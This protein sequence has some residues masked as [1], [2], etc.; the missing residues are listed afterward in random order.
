MNDEKFLSQR[1]SE[2]SIS[3][4]A[5]AIKMK[6]KQHEQPS[7]GLEIG[8]RVERIN[9]SNDGFLRGMVGTVSDICNSGYFRV[10]L[11]DGH[12]VGNNS[13]SNLKIVKEDEFK[14]GDILE[15]IEDVNLDESPIVKVTEVIGNMITHI[16]KGESCEVIVHKS[17]FKRTDKK[18]EEEWK[19]ITK[20]CELKLLSDN[21]C[22]CKYYY[23]ELI[24]EGSE[25]ARVNSR[26]EGSKP[27]VWEDSKFKVE[28][29]NNHFR[30]LKKGG[31]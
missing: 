6:E 30:I 28:M 7:Y 5:E 8:V 13:R 22:D 21:D 17:S 31:E 2:M 14:V 3:E 23:I 10:K 16:H 15:Q 27:F 20:D 1:V 9:F 26:G 25:I 12:I 11:S 29:R 4:L 18:F 24:Y 19:D